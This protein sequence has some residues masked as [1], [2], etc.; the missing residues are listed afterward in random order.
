MSDSLP[1]DRVPETGPK[2]A[3][4]SQSIPK[5]WI[6][7]VSL[8]LAHAVLGRVSGFFI[9][10]N[11]PLGYMICGVWLSQPILIA[12]WT[13]LAPQRF[14]IRFL[15]G[16]LS[17]T[18]IFFAIGYG[19]SL[20]DPSNVV[21]FAI[22]DL[23]LFIVASLMF[24]LVRRLSRWQII[25]FYAKPVSLDYQ[26]YQFGIKHLLILTTILALALGLFRTLLL[27]SRN[28]SLPEISD[29]AGFACEI[30]L[31]L[32]P[33]II[34]IWLT[35]AYVKNTAS[36][37]IYALILFGIVDVAA[38]SIFKWLEQNHPHNPN[39]IQIFL[40]VQ[41]GASLSMFATTLV[42]RL[43]GFRMARVRANSVHIDAS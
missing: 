30:I 40:F 28:T 31:I 9:E 16:F 27:I 26:S 38:F 8:V 29:I 21:M 37:I 24:L 32:F 36:S 19:I 14:F 35:L 12:I 11:N 22:I 33:I 1:P 4:I 39:L 3:F 18:L 41:L 43:C 2:K 10:S 15:W 6:V 23:V 42:I 13:A 20:Y 7:L 25:H 34:I 5:Y 17:F